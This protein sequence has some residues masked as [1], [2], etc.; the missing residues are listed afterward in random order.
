MELTKDTYLYLTQF[1]DDRTILNMLSVNKKYN[2]E[3]FFKQVMERKYP[4]LIEFKKPEQSWKQF[5]ISMVYCISKIEETHGIPYYPVEGYNPKR[6][7]N[8]PKQYILNRIM[9]IAAINGQ[10]DII[11]LMIEKGANDFNNTM[12]E[13]ASGGHIDIVKLMIQQGA[14]DFALAMIMA[15]DGGH[16][17]IVELMIEKG[18]TDFDLAIAKA[19]LYG[20]QNILNI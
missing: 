9:R 14:T 12:V 1:A 5:F 20:R 2:N 10:I 4:L 13:A 15:S 17:D 3:Q 11:K 19:S 6:Y 7:C 18:V 8:R 16:K